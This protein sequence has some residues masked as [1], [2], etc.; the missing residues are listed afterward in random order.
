MSTRRDEEDSAE[1]VADIEEVLINLHAK[2][3]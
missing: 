1:D 2:S 3:Y